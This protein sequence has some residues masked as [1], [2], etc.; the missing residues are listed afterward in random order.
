MGGFQWKGCVI[1]EVSMFLYDWRIIS[2]C[3]AVLHLP[4]A[5]PT[6]PV[7]R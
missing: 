2:L 7:A 6:H 1:K 4:T 5:P 3:H